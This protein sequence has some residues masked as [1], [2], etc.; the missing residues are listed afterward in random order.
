MFFHLSVNIKVKNIFTKSYLF[1]LT[2]FYSCS[3]NTFSH[4]PLQLEPSFGTYLIG[5]QESVAW[6]VDIFHF[7][8]NDLD[9]G[10][11]ICFCKE[12]RLLC[13][14]RIIL[15]PASINNREVSTYGLIN[16]NKLKLFIPAG[17]KLIQEDRMVEFTINMPVNIINY[18]REIVNK[19]SPGV[20]SINNDSQGDFILLDLM[21]K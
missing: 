15:P 21:V 14:S 19:I 13:Y 1:L 6:T 4:K 5:C 9:C 12:A 10:Y 20:Y 8:Y 2:I 3:N 7:Y 17:L 11:E 16:G 18:K